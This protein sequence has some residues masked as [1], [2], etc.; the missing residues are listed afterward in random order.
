V[1]I[2]HALRK[3]HV[4]DD[5][6]HPD[7]I[8]RIV[9]AVLLCLMFFT[10]GIHKMMN[11]ASTKQSLLTKIPAWPLPDISVIVVVLIEV[12]CPIIIIWSLIF[13]R[14]HEFAKGSVMTML[15]FTMIVTYI[16]HPPNFNKKYMSN[17]PF[18]SNL[19]VTGG[20][21]TLYSSL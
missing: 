17:I 13:S 16:Y 2:I 4:D 18:F 9:G 1:I 15:I 20:L 5:E 11:F 6:N 10:S 3:M 7:P 14:K 8:L 19:S 12:L 21:L